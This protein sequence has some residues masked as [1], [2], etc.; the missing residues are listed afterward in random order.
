MV[1]IPAIIAT[2]TPT[3]EMAMSD[4]TLIMIVVKQRAIDLVSISDFRLH[5]LWLKMAFCCN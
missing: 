5:I 2:I 1:V 3:S 4:Q